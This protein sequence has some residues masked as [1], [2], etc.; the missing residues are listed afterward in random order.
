M[1]GHTPR[2][3]GDNKHAA[4]DR[5]ERPS[6]EYSV[7][8]RKPPAEHRFRKGKSGNPK[9]RPKNAKNRVPKGQGLDFG[10]QPANQMLLEEAYR[11]ISVREGDNVVELPVIKAVFRAMGVSAMKG[12]RLAQAAMAELVR[13]IEEEDR[14]IRSRLFET[15]CEY[16]WEWERLIEHARTHNLPEPSP[17]PHPDDVVLDLHRAEVRYAGP[18]TP[19]EK[20]SWDRMLAFRDE[21]QTDISLFADRFRRAASRKRP[22][23]DHMKMLAGH[24][25]RYTMM[26]DRMNEP[27]SD[28]YKKHLE[29]RFHPRF[30]EGLMGG[31]QE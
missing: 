30:I 12:N 24:W 6:A 9:G 11:T 7:G 21:L 13:G 17:L 29:D 2:G 5:S 28:R 15:A 20:K 10:T 31:E 3:A 1:M 22:P 8:Y 27:L 23:L 16:K 26:Y 25:E 4:E 18:A 14:Q 19:E